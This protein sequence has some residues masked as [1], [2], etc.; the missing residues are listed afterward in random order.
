MGI[1]EIWYV[2]VWSAPF[3]ETEN[4]AVGGVAIESAP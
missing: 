4:P 3:N 1:G 2:G